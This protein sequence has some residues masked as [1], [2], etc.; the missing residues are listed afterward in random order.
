MPA[1]TVS[2]D[3]DSFRVD[4][5]ELVKHGLGQFC[6]DVAGHLVALVPRGFGRV[7]VEARAA[8]E[9]EGF[10]FALDLQTT[11][12]IVASDVVLETGNDGW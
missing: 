6:R 10:V 5:L 9:I 8:A 11:Y 2:K 7:D 4:L 12:K 1:H 3:A